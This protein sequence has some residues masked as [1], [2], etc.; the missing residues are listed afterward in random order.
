MKM[1]FNT[2]CSLRKR[3][4]IFLALGMF[5][6][7]SGIGTIIHPVGSSI[8]PV[9]LFSIAGSSIAVFLSTRGGAAIRDEM[10]RRADVMSGYYT[11]NATLYSLFACAI[12]NYFHSLPMDVN[13]FILSMMVFMSWTFI[14]IRFYLLRKGIPE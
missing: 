1:A 2:S 9:V 3:M 6:L 10:V 8:I 13:G 5:C 14:V 4:T 12:V 11:T 7:V